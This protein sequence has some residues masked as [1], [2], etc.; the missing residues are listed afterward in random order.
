M[1]EQRPPRDLPRLE[2]LA[3][4]RKNHQKE[5]NYREKTI[6]TESIPLPS[7]RVEMLAKARPYNA[8]FRQDKALSTYIKPAVLKA[9]ASPRTKQLCQPI[10]RPLGQVLIV[11]E[12]A[13]DIKPNALKAKASSRIAE[14]ALPQSR[15]LSDDTVK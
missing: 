4:P 9:I 1:K 12:D 10:D 2:G 7:P 3:K 14:L 8:D 6:T 15:Y 11:K 5:S 13:F